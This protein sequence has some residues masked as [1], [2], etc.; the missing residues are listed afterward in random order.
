MTAKSEVNYGRPNV[1]ARDILVDFIFDPNKTDFSGGAYT[2]R[3]WRGEFYL[4][5]GKRWLRQT[6]VEI[7]RLCVD[8]IEHLNKDD[9][10]GKGVELSP[11]SN[12]ISDVL[13]NLS[14]KVR[15]PE[16]RDVVDTWLGERAEYHNKTYNTINLKNGL[17][18]ITRDGT[19]KPELINHTPAYFT[20]TKLPFDYDPEAKCPH[21]LSFLDDAMLGREEY[22]TL[23]QQ[24][25]GY[26]F[27]SDLREQKFLLCVGEGANGKTVFFDVLRALVGEN[28]CSQVPLARFGEPFTLYGTVGKTLNATTESSGM[29]EDAAENILKGYVSGDAM[30]F[31]RKFKDPVSAKPTAKIMIAT[32]SLPRFGDRTLGLWRRILLC[33]FEKTIPDACQ[34]QDLAKRLQTELPGILNWALDGLKKLNGSRFIVPAHSKE[35]LEQYRRDCDPARAFLLDNYRPSLNGEYIPCAEIYDHYTEFCRDNGCRPMN[36]QTFGRQVRRIFPQVQRIRAGGQANRQ[37][38]YNG[39]DLIG[40][41][42]AFLA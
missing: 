25:T 39:I 9:D 13:L 29:I 23:L 24:W 4:W 22:I 26:L 36:S 32:N 2:I 38:V 16:Y 11:T 37:Y 17:L 15:I 33:P 14:A 18:L 7:R 27:R 34:V 5:Y 1:I 20:M 42:D 10:L 30:T 31:E 3:W 6:D 8:C 12:R 28:N 40:H 41:A 35:L 21:W 19:E